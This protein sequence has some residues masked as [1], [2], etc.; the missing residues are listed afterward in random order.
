MIEPARFGIEDVD[1]H[2]EIVQAYPMCALL[3]LEVKGQGSAFILDPDIDLV[4]DRF[5]L[6]GGRSF[7]NDEKVGGSVIQVAKIQFE[8][9]LALDVLDTVYDQFV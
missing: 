8:D 4:G 7:T 5:Y 9:V 1:D 3:A 2:V 6:G